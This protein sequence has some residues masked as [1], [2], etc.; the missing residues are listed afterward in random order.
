MANSVTQ[1]KKGGG[2]KKQK[3]ATQQQS[4]IP[5]L[6]AAD[7]TSTVIASPVPTQYPLSPSSAPVDLIY[8]ATAAKADETVQYYQEEEVQKYLSVN[9]GEMTSLAST[10]SL[11]DL[12]HTST[13]QPL[14]IPTI[15]HGEPVSSLLSVVITTLFVV[16][17][18]V[19]G[20][21]SGS[22]NITHDNTDCSDCNMVSV[23]TWHILERPKRSVITLLINILLSTPA[24]SHHF[25]KILFHPHSVILRYCN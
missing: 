5:A 11:G 1:K 22:S 6:P 23:E 3:T 13:L 14:D 12:S 2:S 9:P 16:I 15:V 7:E 20:D 17:I 24:I 10:M 8:N 25:F 18:T 4:T 21:G 19:V